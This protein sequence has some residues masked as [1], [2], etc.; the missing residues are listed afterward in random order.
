MLGIGGGVAIVLNMALSKNRWLSLASRLI[1][2]LL[3]VLFLYGGFRTYYQLQEKGHKVPLIGIWLYRLRLAQE[4]N[5]METH[6]YYA[7][8]IEGAPFYEKMEM[9]PLLNYF[10]PSAITTTTL[11]SWE[12]TLASKPP[13]SPLYGCYAIIES[14]P[15]LLSRTS[16]SK[17]LCSEELDCSDAAQSKHQMYL[18]GRH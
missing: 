4:K 8:P 16:T 15:E 13:C 7:G 6:S 12:I 1:L 10:V 2:A 3:L 11:P 5:F 9:Q 17:S 14:G 18:K